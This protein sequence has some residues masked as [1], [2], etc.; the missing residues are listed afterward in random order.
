MTSEIVS[1]PITGADQHPVPHGLVYIG[2]SS[3]LETTEKRALEAA[4]IVQKELGRQELL[5]SYSMISVY[6]LYTL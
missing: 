6:A 2:C 5:E 4:A 1:R 3:P